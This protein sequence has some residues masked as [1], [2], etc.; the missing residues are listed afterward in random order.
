M[1]EV[2][3]IVGGVGD[4]NVILVKLVQSLNA[5]FLIA[6][7]LFPNVTPVKLLQPWNA[8]EPIC[9]LLLSVASVKLVQYENV[10]LPFQEFTEEGTVTF[11]NPL[12]WNVP[13]PSM[14]VTVDGMVTLVIFAAL[15]KVD[16]FNVVIS[17]GIVKSVTSELF[18]YKFVLHSLKTA[19]SRLLKFILQKLDKSFM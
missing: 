8:Y 3:S 7:I 18:T 2:L 19:L 11:L 15:R 9:P 17:F 12:C 14:L 4:S 6:V 1:N 16:D 10:S 13:L 5:A